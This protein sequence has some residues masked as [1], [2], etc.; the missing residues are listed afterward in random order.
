[1]GRELVLPEGLPSR[2]NGLGLEAGECILALG[3][4]PPLS[5]GSVGDLLGI[6]YLVAYAIIWHY[7]LAF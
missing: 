4:I 7:F 1:M 3:P 5:E 6:T 2:H